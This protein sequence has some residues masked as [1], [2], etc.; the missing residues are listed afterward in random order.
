MPTGYTSALYD[1]KKQTFVEFVMQCARSFG[2]CID[3]RDDSWDKPIPEEFTSDDS[4]HTERLEVARKK[5]ATA[6]NM[7][8]AEA[9]T[10]VQ[11]E[12]DRAMVAYYATIAKEKVIGARYTAM[13]NQ[14]NEWTPPTDDHNNLKKF[15]IEQLTE[16]IRHD[17]GYQPEKPHKLRPQEWLNQQLTNCRHDVAYHLECLNKEKE[18]LESNNKWVRDLR[19]SLA[20]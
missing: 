15:M 5:L 4:Y 10:A 1:G 16:S 17:C 2:A 13:L 19:K 3:M 14:V 11:E 6:Q 12:Y 7:T 18:R 9:E 8:F 20:K